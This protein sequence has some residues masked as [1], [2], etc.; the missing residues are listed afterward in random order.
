MLMTYKYFWKTCSCKSTLNIRNVEYTC[1][2]IDTNQAYCEFKYQ[3][4]ADSIYTSRMFA[5]NLNRESII[6]EYAM[7]I[8]KVNKPL[9]HAIVFRDLPK[10][11]K[12]PMLEEKLKAIT[13]QI[14]YIL[15]FKEIKS[16]ILIRPTVRCGGAGG[17]E[18]CRNAMP[19][20]QQYFNTIQLHS[21]A[22]TS[23]HMPH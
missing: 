18:Y 14:K 10:G 6:I 3:S 22:F 21:S 8:A 1:L 15:P 4:I 20:A 19:K 16:T 2:K 11:Y 7:D 12:E 17:R 23:R 5:K 13:N 9:W